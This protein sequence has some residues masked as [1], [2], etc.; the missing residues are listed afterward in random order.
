[1]KLRLTEAIVTLPKSVWTFVATNS[2]WLGGY[3][4]VVT[5]VALF[6]S[7]RGMWIAAAVL[8]PVAA[9]KEFYIDPHYETADESGGDSG[10][11]IDFVGYMAGMVLALGAYYL[12]ARFRG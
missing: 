3:A 2:H 9:F 7:E 11:V 8:V 6:S 1:M 5:P 4:I 10:D 12:T